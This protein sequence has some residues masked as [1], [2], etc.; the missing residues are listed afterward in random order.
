MV[1]TGSSDPAGV[2][3]ISIGYRATELAHFLRKRPRFPTLPATI[4][5]VSFRSQTMDNPESVKAHPSPPVDSDST[6]GRSEA[7]LM[8]AR[9][10]V[11]QSE[12]A[13]GVPH[14]RILLAAGDESVELA[15]LPIIR[16]LGARVVQVRNASGLSKALQ[17][18]GNFD[19]VLSDG[20]LPGG[21]GLGILA[22]ARQNGRRPP[23]IIV[24]SV[25]QSLIRVVVGGGSRTV[26]ATRVVNDVALIEL[27]E[28]LLGLHDS[29]ASSRHAEGAV[30]NGVAG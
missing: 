24:Q 7:R 12:Q 21:T 29:P 23:F 10:A 2:D 9:P 17:E 11:A 25:H 8:T 30:A 27:A 15:A 19:L 1:E 13:A 14:P 18:R 5:A 3:I 22:M 6:T 28:D 20:H 26:L 4:E 16:A